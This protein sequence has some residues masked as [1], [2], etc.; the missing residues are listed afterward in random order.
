MLATEDKVGLGRDVGERVKDSTLCPKVLMD[1][2]ANERND[3][4]FVKCIFAKTLAQH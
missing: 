4:D 2:E 1:K 3:S